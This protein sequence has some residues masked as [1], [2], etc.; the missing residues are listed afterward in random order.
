[1]VSFVSN[2]STK[3]LKGQTTRP[4]IA[5]TLLVLFAALLLNGMVFRHAHR[6][7]DG[8][9]IT[10]AHPYKPVGDSPYQSNSH[11]TNELYILDLITNG[12]FVH[13]PVFGFLALAVVI[14]V[15]QQV[16]FFQYQQRFLTRFVACL[17]LRGP[18]LF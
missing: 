5:R 10:H 12:G 1:M 6:L 14:F 2:Q 18:P 8:K 13:N 3:M 9:I 15:T 17:S 16:S 4:I 7:S 11:T